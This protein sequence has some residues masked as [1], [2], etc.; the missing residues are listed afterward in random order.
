MIDVFAILDMVGGLALFLFGMHI[1]GEGLSKLSGGKMESLLERLTSTPIKGVLLGAIVTAVI[2]SSSATTVMVV[3]FVNSGIMKLGQAISV[4]MGANIGTTITSWILSLT[5]LQSD[6]FFVKLLKPTSFSPIMAIIGIALIMFSKKEKKHNIGAVMVGFAV[7]M[8][9]MDAMSGAVKPLAEVPEFTNLLLLFSNPILG[10]IVGAVVTAVIQSSSASVGILQAL[11]MTGQVGN[12][13][14]VPIIMG[15]NIGTCATALIS[16]LGAGKNAKRAAL[17]HFYFNL[18]GT[19]VFMGAFYLLHAVIDFSFM[20]EMATPFSIAVV[21]TVFNVFATVVLFPFRRLLEK[22]AVLTVKDNPN[23]LELP[24]DFQVLDDHFLTIPALA[25]EQCR[26]V[27]K[28]MSKLVGEALFLAMKQVTDYNA[29]EC[30]LIEKMEERVDKYEDELSKY[31]LKISTTNLSE[32]DSQTMSEILHSAGDF[33]RISDHALN[34][35]ESATEMHEKKAAFSPQA[36]EEYRIFESAVKA[37]VEK[38]F[39]AF[40]NGDVESARDVEPLEDVIDK[41]NDKMKKSHVRRLR[42]GEC[43]VEMGFI[44]ND[45][46]IAF[47][48]VADHCSN[49]AIGVLQTEEELDAHDYLET[50]DKGEHTHYREKYLEYKQMYYMDVKDK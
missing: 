11:C 22:L 8:F 12:M 20:T 5:G 21:H 42:K 10:M 48:R 43:T 35:M 34:I 24:D 30:K 9:G 4:I 23:E 7:L 15:Q 45:I 39:T 14:A 3:G 37:I 17:V 32:K 29:E 19:V 41:L 49:I 47:E 6:A 28:K 50:L 26:T 16:A 36:M 2:Q 27:A 18:I 44:L 46:T 1:L 38:T 40:V 25:M 13:T 33:E 31:L